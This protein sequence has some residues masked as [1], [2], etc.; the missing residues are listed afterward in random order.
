MIPIGLDD[1]AHGVHLRLAKFLPDM[2]DGHSV[3]TGHDAAQQMG[4]PL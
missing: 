1:F 4:D 2:T 3:R